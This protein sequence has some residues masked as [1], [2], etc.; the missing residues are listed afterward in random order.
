MREWGCRDY[1]EGLPKEATLKPF[2][3]Q[4]EGRDDDAQRV[5]DRLDE[6]GAL[7]CIQQAQ[8]WDR[9]DG[10]AALFPVLE[11]AGEIA[12]PLRLNSKIRIRRIE[13]LARYRDLHEP[14]VSNVV[15]DIASPNYGRVFKWQI[16]TMGPKD[17]H[18]SRIY[19]Y[20]GWTPTKR[21]LPNSF[22]L[23][24][25]ESFYQPWTVYSNVMAASAAGAGRIGETRIAINGWRKMHLERDEEAIAA[26]KHQAQESAIMRSVLRMLIHDKVDEVSDAQITLTG[27]PE[28]VR[29]ARENV[30][31]ASGFTAQ[32]FFGL[33]HQGMSDNDETGQ[34]RDEAVI[35]EYRRKKILPAVNFLVPFVLAELG[36]E[37]IEEWKVTFPPLREE[38]PLEN[39]QRWNLKTQGAV[40]AIGAGILTENEVRPRWRQEDDCPYDVS[41]EDFVDASE[42]D[43][44]L[45]GFEP[46]ADQGTDEDA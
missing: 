10:A 16:G 41:D 21:Y 6:L 46:P 23:S 42:R 8:I 9:K 28:I 7:D 43:G 19:V 17:C 44:E 14:V 34:Q 36:L 27:L 11:N 15:D 37:D 29:L 31:G 18:A 5:K 35:S 33:A 22:G 30:A 24:V 38:T 2:D 3:I 25:L 32:R 20:Q 12:T 40:S 13:G 1:V 45:M 39:A 4:I 26:V